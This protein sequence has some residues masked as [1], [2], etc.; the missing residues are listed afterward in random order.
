MLSSA[1]Q[2]MENI[3]LSN[4]LYEWAHFLTMQEMEI[5]RCVIVQ[6]SSG[7][8]RQKRKAELFFERKALG[9][10]TVCNAQTIC[11]DFSS[12]DHQ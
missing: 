2:Q 9:K 10:D 12:K 4:I 8:E 11:L 3:N 5:I 1:Q 6:L 7:E